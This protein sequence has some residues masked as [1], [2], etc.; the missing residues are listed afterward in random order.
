MHLRPLPLDDWQRQCP[1]GARSEYRFGLC[2]KCR[3]R[4]A[5]FRRTARARRGTRV[6][7]IF[8]RDAEAV[9]R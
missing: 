4:A 1:C 7:R 3:A 2:R 8:R 5:W 6:R 9:S